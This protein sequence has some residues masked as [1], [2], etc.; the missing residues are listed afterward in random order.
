MSS[1]SGSG[2]ESSGSD[3]SKKSIEEIAKR[4]KENKIPL[5]VWVRRI[6]IAVALLFLISTAFMNGAFN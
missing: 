2:S 4:L 6:K 1:K 5:K 3:R